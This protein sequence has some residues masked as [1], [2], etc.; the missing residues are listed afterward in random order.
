MSGSV[1]YIRAA[2]LRPLYV[3]YEG[4]FYLVKRHLASDK[5]TEQESRYVRVGEFL[6]IELPGR[7]IPLAVT[8]LTVLT[9]QVGV[10]KFVYA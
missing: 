4:K 7:R 1:V 6:E 2:D 8:L 5:R 9:D 3:S 10:P